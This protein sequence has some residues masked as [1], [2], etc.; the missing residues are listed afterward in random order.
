MKSQN[1]KILNHLK[2]TSI[3]PLQA[4]RLYGCMRLSG[5][6]FDLKHGQYDGRHYRIKTDMIKVGG[7]WVA[8]YSL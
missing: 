4:L 7:K 5:R 6:I 2:L 3:T 1:A 8:Q